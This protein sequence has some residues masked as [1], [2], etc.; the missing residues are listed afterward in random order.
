MYRYPQDLYTD[1]RIEEKTTTFIHLKDYELAQNKTRKT[2]GALIRVF[3]GDRWYYSSITGTQGVQAAID[4]LSKMAGRCPQIYENE[5]VKRLEVNREKCIRYEGRRLSDVS[6]ADKLNLIK[7]YAN[8]IRESGKARSSDVYYKGVYCLKR[9]MSSKGADVEFDK[10]F[11]TVAARY[12]I[13]VNEFPFNGSW[14][15]VRVHFEDLFNNEAELINAVS[16][17]VD[18]AL[19]A[20]PVVPGDYTCIL[21]PAVAGVFAHESFGHKSE[22]DFMLGDESM[23]REWRL[24]KQVGSPILNIID[25][26]ID[27]GLGYTYFDDEGCRARTNYI[28]KDG[29]LTGRLHSA[30]TAAA[31][32]EGVTG[33]ARAID[34][35]Y[36]PIVRMTSTWIGAGTQTKEELFSG[37]KEG[38]YIEDFNHGSGMSTFTIAPRTAYMIR[39]GKIAQPVKISVITGNVMRTLHEIDGVSDKV[40]MG[41][42]AMGGCGKMEQQGLPVQFGGPYVRINGIH[43]Q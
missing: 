35:E 30:M 2:I 25:S 34:F 21:S 11:C 28:I 27:E 14:N 15:N 38:L 22:S 16:R 10:Q 17:D 13:S 32:S 20:V 4:E 7:G 1:V 37:V 40:E 41:S 24:G 6:K 9:F 3:D 12:A 31:L 39:D 8:V 42:S 26:G 29:I 19:N 23:R 33:N 18:Y 5:T 36:E 43:A